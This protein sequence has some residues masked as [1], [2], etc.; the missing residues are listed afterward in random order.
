MHDRGGVYGPDK[1]GGSFGATGMTVARCERAQHTADLVERHFTA[2]TL[3]RLW[4]ADF[5]Y[6]MNLV[7]RSGSVGDDYDNAL[8][9]TAIG[10][11]KTEK[12][13]RADRWKTLAD[14]EIA[15]LEWSTGSITSDCT[16]GVTRGFRPTTH[17]SISK[18]KT[19]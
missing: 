3:N 16:L 9:E 14:V 12:I 13:N 15:T 1:C 17:L 4:V 19:Q 2:T 8:A 7:R 6:V 18:D 11:Y 5:T 10:L